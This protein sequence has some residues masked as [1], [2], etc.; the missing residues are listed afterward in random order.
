MSV[1]RT[2]FD[3]VKNNTYGFPTWWWV[4]RNTHNVD[5]EVG[6]A[7]PPPSEHDAAAARVDDRNARLL[8]V[9]VSNERMIQKYTAV[10]Q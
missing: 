2:W 9:A 5:Q 1:K 7:A 10:A 3:I 8:V 4:Y 6:T